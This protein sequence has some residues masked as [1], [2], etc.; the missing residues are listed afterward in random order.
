MFTNI[1]KGLSIVNL[2]DTWPKVVDYIKNNFQKPPHYKIVSDDLFYV[3]FLLF[4]G[5][6]YTF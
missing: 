2:K 3:I 4:M 6:S 1:F 5:Q